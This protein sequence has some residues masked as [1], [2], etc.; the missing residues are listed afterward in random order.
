MKS[1]HFINMSHWPHLDLS[2]FLLYLSSCSQTIGYLRNVCCSIRNVSS[3]YLKCIASQYL[4]PPWVL[5]FLRNLDGRRAR[6]SDVFTNY[7]TLTHKGG[8]T[9]ATLK[10]ERKIN[11]DFF[12]LQRSKHQILYN[13][14]YRRNVRK[15]RTFIYVPMY[16][17]TQG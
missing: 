2:L 15:E 10:Y 12:L 11:R 17:Y 9:S 8:L 5:F 1:C 3:S 14:F 16:K 7:V 4:W 6:V 13:H